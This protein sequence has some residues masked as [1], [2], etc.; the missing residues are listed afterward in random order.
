MYEGTVVSVDGTQLDSAQSWAVRLHEPK[1]HMVWATLSLIGVDEMLTVVKAAELRFGLGEAKSMGGSFMFV[2][3]NIE[4]GG[5]TL[6]VA[7]KELSGERERERNRGK[8]RRRRA[9]L[10]DYLSMPCKLPPPP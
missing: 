4:Y 7:A 8:R 10:R 3:R 5:T 9:K 2:I 1:V 6:Y